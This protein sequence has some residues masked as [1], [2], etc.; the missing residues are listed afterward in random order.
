MDIAALKQKVY[1][2]VEANAEK[3]MEIGQT[4]WKNPEPGFREYKTASLAAETFTSL[5]LQYQ[6][7]L[8]LTG[9]IGR[10]SC[11]ERV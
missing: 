1:D 2:A 8:A 11:R 3:I 10:A 4:V 7:Q 9:E 5:G 6:D